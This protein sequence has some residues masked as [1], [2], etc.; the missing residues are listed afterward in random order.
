MLMFDSGMC[1]A[2]VSTHQGT[3]LPARLLKSLTGR[4]SNLMF[5]GK[6]FSTNKKNYTIKGVFRQLEDGRV[7]VA[8]LIAASFLV[9]SSTMSPFGD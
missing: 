4:T 3:Q 8:Y 2:R 5:V 7:D 9:N 6:P 1:T